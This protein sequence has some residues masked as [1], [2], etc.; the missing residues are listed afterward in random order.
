MA[1]GATL[2][3]K[4]AHTAPA[5]PRSI[6]HFGPKTS[7]PGGIASVLD[8]YTEQ[9]L[10][11]EAR[12]AP[13]WVPDRARMLLLSAEALR[14]LASLP[15]GTI[16]HV[17]LSERGSFLRE[18]AILA[19]ARA[20][21]LA[22]VATMHGADFLEFSQAHPRLSAS[23]LGRAQAIICLSERTRDRVL[24]LVPSAHAVRIANPVAVSEDPTPAQH[25][26]ELVLF[27]GELGT[28]KGVDVLACAWRIVAERRLAARCVLVGPRTSLELGVQD[29]L[30]VRG[31]V[32]REVIARLLQE[33]RVL[34]L[35]SRAEAMPMIL[36]EAQ[37][38]ARP[39]ISTPVGSIAELAEHGGVLVPVDDAHALAGAIETLLA[40]SALAGE[41]G[42]RGHRFARATRS[43][44]VIDA[45]LREL[46]AAL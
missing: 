45:Q 32:G 33:A 3:A 28:R 35:P 30:E 43:F 40:D 39:F 29:R 10:G 1:D 44:E 42:A 24:S 22:T 23:V 17:H 7:F 21:G 12:L 31:A 6:C 16:V 26:S 27:A 18:G 34:V 36:M 4:E 13:T 20:R 46:Y 19:S 38:A 25:T 41:L 9:Q 8:A 2:S 37:G 15:G 14:T 11:G 5:R